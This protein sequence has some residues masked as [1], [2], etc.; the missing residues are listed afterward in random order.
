MIPAHIMVLPSLPMN[1]VG[2]V[3]RSR[4]H[5]PAVTIIQPSS[6]PLTDLEN[7]I[8]AI[9]K[10]ILSLSS[11]DLDHNFFDAGGSS[12]TLAL[13]EHRLHEITDKPFTITDLFRHTTIRSLAQFL[14]APDKSE[15]DAL[16]AE[17][18]RRAARQRAVFGM[19]R[20]NSLVQQGR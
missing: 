8:V 19:K 1:A 20:P 14:A 3:D 10:E 16:L 18:Q 5:L 13:V 11:V 6:A 15:A 2:K 7:L 12:I 4:L 9:W 17:S